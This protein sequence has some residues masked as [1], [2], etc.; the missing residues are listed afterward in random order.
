MGGRCCIQSKNREDNR[1][2]AILDNPAP[3]EQMPP[4]DQATA[5]PRVDNPLPPSYV[6]P[7]MPLPFDAYEVRRAS[8]SGNQA[9][10]TALQPSS[11][12]AAAGDSNADRTLQARL[13][14]PLESDEGGETNAA[15]EASLDV[16]DE[17]RKSGESSTLPVFDDEEDVCP[18]CLEEYDEQNPKNMTDCDHHY[19]LSCILQW[20][21]KN[22]T[23]PVCGKVNFLHSE[24]DN[25]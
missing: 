11:T 13:K 9:G 18:I 22:N 10:S 7:P 6:S 19:H 1:A 5:D 8:P 24:N 15:H 4:P 25:P 21:E 3:E 23:C 2:P 14:Q 20:K 17:N 16:E 12:Q